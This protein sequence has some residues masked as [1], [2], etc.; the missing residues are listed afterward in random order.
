[1]SGEYYLHTPSICDPE[2]PRSQS[3]EEGAVHLI[4]TVVLVNIR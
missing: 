4:H 1:M 2:G 3:G